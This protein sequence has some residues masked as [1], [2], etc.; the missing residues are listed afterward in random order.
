MI[1]FVLLSGC[2]NPVEAPAAAPAPA[3]PAPAEPAPAAPAPAAPAPAAPAPAAPAPAEPAPAAADEADTVVLG[4]IDHLTGSMASVG[5]DALAAKKM[6]VDDLNAAGGILGKQVVLIS[7]D[8]EN[9]AAVGT[10]AATKLITNDNVVAIDGPHGSGVTLAVME[11]LEQYGV[12]AV[13]HGCSNPKVTASG[14]P[15][16]NRGILGDHAQIQILIKYA[17][18]SYGVTKLGFIHSNDDFGVGGLNLA[19]AAAE[20]LGIEIVTE[21]HQVEDQDMSAQ[22]S[23]LISAGCNGLLMWEH[24]M[25]AATICK[26]VREMGWDAQIFGSSGLSD[27]PVFEISNGAVD[28][29]IYT[30]TFYASNP[31]PYIQDWVARYNELVGRMPTQTAANAYDATMI[32]AQAIER[33]GSLDRD[34]IAKEIRNTKNYKSL[35]GPMSFDPATG[36]YLGNVYLIQCKNETK[37][38]EYIATYDLNTMEQVS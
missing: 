11:V 12:P 1:G 33:V 3:A 31:D 10:T 34:A 9:T 27:P 38:Y 15:W 23:N 7:E 19:T 30:A 37:S 14:N 20:K 5:A 32:I 21:T 6:A 25:P 26:Q 28:G 2:V 17:M 13:A 8:D 18:E 35:K 24:Y 29:A 16:I 36:D 4:A 22:I